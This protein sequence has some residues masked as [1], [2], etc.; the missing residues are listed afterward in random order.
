MARS[1]TPDDLAIRKRNW[2]FGRGEAQRRWW[3]GGDPGRTAFFL[4]L[5]H[6]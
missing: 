3:H 1:R 4:S 5:I 2:K 6:I